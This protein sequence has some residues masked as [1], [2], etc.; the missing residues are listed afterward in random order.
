MKTTSTNNVSNIKTPFHYGTEASEYIMKIK[1]EQKYAYTFFFEILNP[2]IHSL[3]GRL[4]GCYKEFIDPVEVANELYLALWDKG[5]WSRLHSYEGK[6]SFFSW[7]STVAQHEAFRH[8]DEMGYRRHIRITP[9]NTRLRLLRQPLEIR[10]EVVNL[11]GVPEFHRYLKLR[12]VDKLSDDLIGNILDYDEEEFKYVRQAAVRTLKTILINTENDY[13]DL[14]LRNTTDTNIYVGEE[15]LER[16]ADSTMEENAIESYLKA[17]HG[18]DFNKA[19]YEKRLEA[20]I[21]K[22]AVHIGLKNVTKQN[23]FIERFVYEVKPEKLAE[24]FHVKRSY[25]DNIKSKGVKRFGEYVRA[26]CRG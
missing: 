9:G 18:I 19:D 12:Y 1:S 25:V 17:Y 13:T 24:K 6:S 5:T 26:T 11:V 3:T 20:Y 16:I 21:R 2:M 23:I 8:F 10:K 22:N 15:A 7:L 4:R 14:V